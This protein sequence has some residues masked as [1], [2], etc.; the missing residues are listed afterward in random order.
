MKINHLIKPWVFLS[1]FIFA[2]YTFLKYDMIFMNN[3]EFWYYK[4]YYHPSWLSIW[5]MLWL[6]NILLQ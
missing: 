2:Y 1:L 5:L 6:L 3:Y 4:T